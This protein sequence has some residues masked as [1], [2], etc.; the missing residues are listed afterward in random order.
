MYYLRA[1]TA[2]VFLRRALHSVAW[3]A[4]AWA[5]IA[6]ATGGVGWMIGPLRLSSRQPF[7]PALAGLIAAA[8]CVWRFPRAEIDADAR[9]SEKALRPL[10]MVV[11]PAAALIALV[12][13]IHFGSFAAAGSDSY[14]YVSQADLWLHGHLHIEQPFVKQFSWPFREWTFAPL[15]Y[16]PVNLSG[17]IVPTYAPGLP[18]LMAVFLG[19]FGADGPFFV[20]PILG[21]LGIWFTYLLGKEVTRSRSVGVCAALLLLA[22]PVFLA[23]LMLPMT[24]VPVGVCWTLVCLLALAEPRPRAHAAGL[25]AGAAL[26]IRPNLLLLSLAPVAAWLWPCISRPNRWRPALMRVIRFGLG[27]APALAAIAFINNNLYGSPFMSGYGSLEDTYHLASALQNLRNYGAWLVQS[28]TPLVVMALVPFFA[29]GALRQ[30]EEG[31][32]A[33][34]CLAMLMVATLVSYVFYSPFNAWFYLRFL[35]PALPAMFVLM[36]AAIRF[37]ALTLPLPARA[38]VATLVCLG[39]VALGFRFTRDQFLFNQREFEQRHVRAAQYV[40]RLTPPDAVILAVQHS[41]SIRYYAHRISLR[42]DWL[43]VNRLDAVILELAATGHKPYIVVDDWEEAEF[44][45][46]FSETSRVGQLD[47]RPLSRVL[48]NPEVRIFDPEGRAEAPAPA[49]PK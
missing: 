40:D 48:G 5:L 15:G 31:S 24:D 26:M 37:G 43:P 16:R 25:V 41:G 39:C 42:Y 6:V 30:D 36:A 10:L 38:P 8:I 22:C 2:H 28:Q 1:V 13:G 12:I 45:R 49:P 4:P 17:T 21:A 33:R 35:L 47:W 29:R 27:I 7:R 34:A 19:L 18:M 20:V 3:L 44:R 32:S 23:H 11:P 14:G 46:R 9:W